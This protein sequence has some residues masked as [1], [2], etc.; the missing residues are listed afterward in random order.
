MADEK[1]YVS[2]LEQ[3]QISRVLLMWMNQYP[4]KP[5]SRIEF[6][7]LP[8]SGVGMCLSTVTAAFKT[9]ENIDGSYDAQYQFAILYRSKPDDSGARLRMDEVLNNL[10]IW[11]ESREDKPALGPGKT[12]LSIDRN[13]TASLIA[14]YPDN[15][16]DYQVLMTMNYEVR[17]EH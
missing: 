5:V 16:E 8:D 2:G 10:G 1:R 7:F 3:D 11:A 6:E 13:S 12:V 4:N 14:K 15:S 9:G 17:G